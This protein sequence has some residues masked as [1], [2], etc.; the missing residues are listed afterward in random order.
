VDDGRQHSGLAER[1]GYCPRAPLQASEGGGMERLQAYVDGLEVVAAQLADIGSRPAREE[2]TRVLVVSDVHMN[3]YG[4]RLASRLAAGD[5][6]PVDAVVLAGDMTNYG[7]RLEATLFVDARPSGAGDHVGGSH[8]DAPAMAA[9]RAGYGSSSSRARG[10][11]SR[12]GRARRQSPAASAAAPRSRQMCS[13]AARRPREAV[14]WATRPVPAHG[15]LQRQPR[16]V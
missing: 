9:S 14:S 8:E 3:A 12:S 11:G 6:S 7:R 16:T 13:R 1:P 10:R 2:V 4:A 15:R 5:G